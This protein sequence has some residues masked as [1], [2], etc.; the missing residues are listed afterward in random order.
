MKTNETKLIPTIKNGQ[1]KKRVI[2]K[3]GFQNLAGLKSRWLNAT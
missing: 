3:N 2:N 1:I